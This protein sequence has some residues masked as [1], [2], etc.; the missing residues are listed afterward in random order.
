[1]KVAFYIKALFEALLLHFVFKVFLIESRLLVDFTVNW[2]VQRAVPCELFA[3]DFPYSCQL[4][5]IFDAMSFP[6]SRSCTR[7]YAWN[8]SSFRGS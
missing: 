5:G 8:S 1:M 7:L 2:I 6:C 4:L 3:E